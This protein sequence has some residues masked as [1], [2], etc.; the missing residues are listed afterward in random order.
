VKEKM[1][2]VHNMK[3]PTWHRGTTPLIY[4]PAPD[5]SDW[6]GITEDEHFLSMLRTEPR[7]PP[8]KIYDIPCSKGKTVPLQAW[9]GPEVSRK[10]RYADFLTTAQYDGKVVRLR[11]RPL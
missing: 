1:N 11:H 4:N 2:S 5:A 3:V 8:S 6:S 7:T 9:I 10:L